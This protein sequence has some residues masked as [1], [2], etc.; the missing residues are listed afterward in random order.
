VGSKEVWDNLKHDKVNLRAHTQVLMGQD[1]LTYPVHLVPD[2]ELRS[3]QLSKCARDVIQQKHEGGSDI[4]LRF[5]LGA[6]HLAL[7]DSGLSY[8]PEDNE[9]GLVLTHEN[10]GVDRV[11]EKMFT[12]AGDLINKP[13]VL[14][15]HMGVA[16][17]AETLV[18]RVG[19]S[20]YEMQTFIYLYLAAKAFNFHGFSLFINNACASG[21]FAL[22]AAV[23]QI[24]GG[25]SP[26][27]V[28]AA[29]DHPL[30]FT[31]YLWFKQMGLYAKDGE[32][33]PFSKDRHGLSLGDGASAVVLEDRER[34][35]ARGAAIYAEYINGG[36]RLEGGHPVLPSRHS[37][38][39]LRAMNEALS[40]SNLEASDIDV[41][42]PHGVSTVI[43]D[44]CEADVIT[45]VFGEFPR[46]P[47]ITAMK[48]YV[49]HNL[50]GSALLET[51]LLLLSMRHGEIPPA[52]NCREPDPKLKLTPVSK[53]T[54]CDIRTAMKMATGFA[55]YHAAVV[56]KRDQ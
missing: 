18:K 10:P 38:A 56:L 51:I 14:T 43:G 47:L 22:E 8:D 28:V 26:A 52:R 33:G 17:I 30:F 45:R 41:L 11:M 40:K 1:C 34:A 50:G 4:D 42:C 37:T 39:Y 29:G 13:S 25:G 21:L 16:Q 53:W 44:V 49:G 2:Q 48:G 5:L 36:F 19:Q 32:M 24:R 20:V 31:K 27:V 46:R 15:H 12:L 9:V 35:L 54:Q 7:T 23:G 55:G 3:V 6:I